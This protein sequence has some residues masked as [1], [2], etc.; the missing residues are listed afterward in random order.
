MTEGNDYRIFQVVNIIAIVATLVV[1]ALANII[2]I[3][4]V[5]T[6]D[7]ADAYPNLFTPPG[8]VFA[9]WGV[10]YTLLAVFV[11][12]QGRAS[13]RNAAY[14]PK[15]GYWYLIGAVGN[16]AWIFLFHYS[17]GAPSLLVAS[18]VPITLLLISLLVT[19]VRL[20]I[21]LSEVPLREKLAVHLPVSVYLGWI[22]LATIAS[23]ASSL[24]VLIPGIP[25]A[26]QEVATAVMVIVAFVLTLLMLIQR[27]DVAFGLVVIWASTGIALKQI[28]RPIIF[29]VAAPVAIL[30]AIL[31]VVLPLL[32]KK[33]I[34]DFYLA[35]D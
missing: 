13:Q 20:G 29:F 21:G 15:I 30:V 23:V 25:I 32:K 24:N 33:K 34:T 7:V 10:I 12:Y 31:I 18:S 3:N 8:W 11:I 27:R 28:A 19:Y 35:R 4:G 5:L 26:T 1:D 17:V 6:G 9:I 22:S 16:I 2:P 14:L